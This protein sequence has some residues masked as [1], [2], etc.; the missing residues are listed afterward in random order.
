M[1]KKFVILLLLFF[2][3]TYAMKQELALMS[4]DHYRAWFVQA[5]G[6]ELNAHVVKPFFNR[7]KMPAAQ[8]QALLDRKAPEWAA[9]KASRLQQAKWDKLKN[10]GAVAI[11]LVGWCC[12]ATY[13]FQERI[14]ELVGSYL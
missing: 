7:P 12:V 11:A 10:C 3:S 13:V 6:D 4:P 2:S 8:Y 5:S 9:Q 1:F 14:T